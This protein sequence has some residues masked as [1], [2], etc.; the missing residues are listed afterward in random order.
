MVRDAR[1]SF[2]KQSLEARSH[3]LEA[4]KKRFESS[5]ALS[6]ARILSQQK[7]ELSSGSGVSFHSGLKSVS[8]AI[9]SSDSRGGPGSIVV[10]IEGTASVD[11]GARTTV[12]AGG[13]GSNGDVVT[14]KTEKIEKIEGVEGREGKEG[15]DAVPL[16]VSP[17]DS[18]S[19]SAV[20]LSVSFSVK[21]EDTPIGA[22]R[23]VNPFSRYHT[24]LLIY[25]HSYFHCYI[26]S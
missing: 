22:S 7:Q 17:D 19:V 10:K 21:M 26:Q 12:S 13:M 23:I 18:L 3:A 9:S 14:V 24:R 4:S 2:D 1:D 8:G 6:A 15:N 16:S 25:F 5:T 11:A 20:P